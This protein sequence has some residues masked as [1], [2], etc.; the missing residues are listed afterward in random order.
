MVLKGRRRGSA[1]GV[2]TGIPLQIPWRPVVNIQV[3]PRQRAGHR[4][5]G[6]F[7]ARI[8]NLEGQPPHDM[9]ISICCALSP[10]VIKAIDKRRRAFI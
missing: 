2:P 1:A 7:A 3:G 6:R 10:W 5:F 8:S 4:G 9:H